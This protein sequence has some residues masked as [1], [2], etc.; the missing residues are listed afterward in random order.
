MPTPR[1]RFGRPIEEEKHLMSH[2]VERTEDLLAVLAGVAHVDGDRLVID[3][4]QRFRSETAA[5]L[6]W[7]AVFTDDE[8]ARETARWIIWEAAQA[9]GARSA[10]IHELY[11]ARGRGEGHGFSGSALNLPAPTF[12]IARNLF[13][14]AP[15]AGG[16]GVLPPLPR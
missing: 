10:S 16:G 6:A 14:A 11:I 1:L 15:G 4:E 7:T 12:D 8:T 5:H 9:L 13:P 2:V 3:D